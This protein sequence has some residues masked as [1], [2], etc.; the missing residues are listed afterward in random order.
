MIP[1][2]E[3]LLRHG[4]PWAMT[5]PGLAAVIAMLEHATP[6]TQASAPPAPAK[7]QNKLVALVPLDGP[8]LA[9]RSGL[10]DAFGITTMDGVRASIA[11]AV[12]DPSIAGV[13]LDIASQGSEAFG[14]NETSDAIHA[15]RGTKPIVAYVGSIAA[16][17]AYWIASAAD[18]VVIDATAMVG[19]IGFVA[20]YIRNAPQTGVTVTEVIS[21]Q[22]PNKG[23]DPASDAGRFEVQRQL[24]A[25]AQVFVESVARNR[26][27][28]PATV[29]ERFGKGGVE[30]GAAAVAAGM[31]DQ[32]GSLRDAI[33]LAAGGVPARTINPRNLSMR[34]ATPAFAQ[35]S[36]DDQI[37]AEWNTQPAI[38]TEFLDNFGIYASYRQAEAAGRV[39][40]YGGTVQ[41]RTG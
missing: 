18:H 40:I 13:V 27:T 41:T 19:S 6:T 7:V 12:N 39:K 2:S 20:R 9:R 1:V 21:S 32:L 26:S 16:S 14:V 37:K 10:S 8:L 23:L 3:I 30:V 25:M 38:R 35:A 22:S 34:T 24:D 5:E 33:T 4:V 36:L 28:T 31:A 17:G 15:M 29:L 11:N